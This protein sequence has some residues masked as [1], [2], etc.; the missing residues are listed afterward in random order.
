MRSRSRAAAAACSPEPEPQAV[1]R[2]A[3][4]RVF[5]ALLGSIRAPTRP[6][7]KERDSGNRE[8]EKRA[9]I[10]SRFDLNRLS[11]KKKNFPQLCALN[12]TQEGLALA[13]QD[14]S[15][16]A[17]SS[18]YLG[19][20]AFSKFDVPSSWGGGDGDDEDDDNDD[21]EDYDGG[22]ATVDL[23]TLADTAALF[24]ALG[25][26]GPNGGA[27]A[28]ELRYP[29]PNREIEFE[30]GGGSGG[31]RGGALAA[32]ASSNPANLAASSSSCSP[33][34]SSM[35]YA[36]VGTA[37]SDPAS[38]AAAA[39]ERERIVKKKLRGVD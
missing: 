27:D 38:V 2:V 23:H 4:A 24:A 36:R 22:R 7:V 25:G 13:W 30:M 33:S 11:K 26:T 21:G 34:P 16:S 17:R 35:T 18:L 32:A 10:F 37:D 1:L 3:D 31:E 6:Q 5:A 39:R 9:S 12:I 20:D 29:G 15:K 8:R 19:R 14:P 28:L